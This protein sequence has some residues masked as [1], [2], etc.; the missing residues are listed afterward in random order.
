MMEN[1]KLENLNKFFKTKKTT[2]R[3]KPNKWVGYLDDTSVIMFVPKTK[4]DKKL[5]KILEGD[6]MDIPNIN[7][8]N[9]KFAIFSKEYLKILLK[10][11]I[12]DKCDDKVFIG[13]D[14]DSPL[15]VEDK[16]N[17]FLLAPRTSPEEVSEMRDYLKDKNIEEEI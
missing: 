17:I 12:E 4:D 11:L 9:Y 8:K 15:I 5:F 7:V 2:G 3:I 10:T 1:K 6:T 16:D 13:I 14:E